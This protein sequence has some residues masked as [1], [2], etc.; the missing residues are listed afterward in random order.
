MQFLIKGEDTEGNEV[1]FYRTYLKE[2]MITIQN[3]HASTYCIID[4]DQVQALIE[5]IKL[6]DERL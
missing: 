1:E 6:T 4:E 5:Y 3:G 2:L